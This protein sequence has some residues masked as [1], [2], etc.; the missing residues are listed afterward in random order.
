MG[1]LDNSDLVHAAISR[2]AELWATLYDR[3]LSEIKVDCI[4]IRENMLYKKGPLI[5]PEMFKEFL[6]PVLY[7]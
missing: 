6:V 5:R 3:V 7:S 1:V 2:L 4:H